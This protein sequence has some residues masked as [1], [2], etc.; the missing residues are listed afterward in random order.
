VKL[1]TIE[2]VKIGKKKYIPEGALLFGVARFTNNR[3]KIHI[4]RAMTEKGNFPCEI[5]VYDSY[6]FQ[7]GIFVQGANIDV[8]P[9]EGVGDVVE[10]VGDVMPNQLIGSSVKGVSKLVQRDVKKMKKI[11]ATVPD[12]YTVYLLDNSQKKKK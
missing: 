5:L 6:D 11:T 10:E 8:Q 1:R 9:E 7:E 12:N 2:K 3:F 4:T